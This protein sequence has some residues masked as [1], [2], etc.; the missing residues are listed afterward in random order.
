[1]L[2]YPQQSSLGIGE[3]LAIIPAHICTTVNLHS[4]FDA[5]PAKHG[6]TMAPGRGPRLVAT[7][8]VDWE[9]KLARPTDVRSSR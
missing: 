9:S 6:P 8:Y 1:V 5:A 3:R 7:S 2:T 4:A